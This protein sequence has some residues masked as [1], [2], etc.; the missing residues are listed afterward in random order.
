M[1][2]GAGE[3][4]AMSDSSFLYS[5]IFKEREEAWYEEG[6]EKTDGHGQGKQLPGEYPADFDLFGIAGHRISLLHRQIAIRLQ[7][8][9]ADVGEHKIHKAFRLFR[10][11]FLVV[12]KGQLSAERIAAAAKIF[13]IGGDS[14]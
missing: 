12:H 8:I 1:L 7:D 4:V 9:S 3:L 5:F 14:I 2:D 11:V 10:E 6:D 13:R